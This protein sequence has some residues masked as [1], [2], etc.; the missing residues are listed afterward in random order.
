MN[1]KTKGSFNA[2]HR[3]IC[4]KIHLVG[5]SSTKLDDV[6]QMIPFSEY[7]RSEKFLKDI[8]VVGQKKLKD[9]F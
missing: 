8:I 6:D 9:L 3:L 4:H 1:S 5:R 2:I 7:R